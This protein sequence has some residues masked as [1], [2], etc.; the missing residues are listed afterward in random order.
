[1]RLTG[2]KGIEQS[3]DRVECH[4]LIEKPM[5]R[6]SVEAEQLISAAEEAH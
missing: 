1:M 4:V 5:T 2:G 3:S 6:S